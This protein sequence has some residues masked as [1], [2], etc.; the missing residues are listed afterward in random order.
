MRWTKFSECFFF[1]QVFE[2]LRWF[3][4]VA[5][6]SMQSFALV[7]CSPFCSICMSL[8]VV[9]FYFFFFPCFLLLF[10]LILWPLHGAHTHSNVYTV[11]ITRSI[12]IWFGTCMAWLFH[13][14]FLE[15][16][17]KIFGCKQ[18]NEIHNH[19]VM[20]FHWLQ[21]IYQR[22]IW[23]PNA[24]HSASRRIS[25]CSQYANWMCTGAS[26]HY[27]DSCYFSMFLLELF[28][29]VCSTSILPSLI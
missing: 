17:C 5:I 19:I 2:Y 12:P 9:S 26:V 8:A 13:N 28:S 18:N 27:E 20:R 21:H 25:E 6:L 4:V 29:L 11:C 24:G 10:G 14:L 7:S 3:F 1:L 22:H 15:V 16:E 23:C